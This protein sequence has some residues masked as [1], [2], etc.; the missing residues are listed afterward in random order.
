MSVGFESDEGP[1]VPPA[2]LVGPGRS[3]LMKGFSGIPLQIKG[4][5]VL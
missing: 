3:Q 1:H 2:Q 4:T 5:F